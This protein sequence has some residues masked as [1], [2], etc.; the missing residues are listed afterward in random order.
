MQEPA[1][2]VQRLCVFLGY[3]KALHGSLLW[4]V[5]IGRDYDDEAPGIAATR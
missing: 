1:A 3:F 4:D 2:R 5:R